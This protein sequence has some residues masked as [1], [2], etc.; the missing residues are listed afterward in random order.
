MTYRLTILLLCD[1]ISSRISEGSGKSCTIQLT[2]LL[3]CSSILDYTVSCRNNLFWSKMLRRK[4]T[5]IN[6]IVRQVTYGCHVKIFLDINML[7]A[8]IFTLSTNWKQL[9]HFVFKT[10]R[11]K[12]LQR[13]WLKIMCQYHISNNRF[14]SG[15]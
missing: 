15:S 2:S 9:Y 6:A 8:I 14:D 13:K 4:K 11:Y 3:I 10:R 5:L 12:I 1:S 7:I